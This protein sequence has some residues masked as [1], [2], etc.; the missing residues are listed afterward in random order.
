MAF[1]AILIDTDAVIVLAGSG[2]L[3]EALAQLGLGPEHAQRL[4]ALRSQLQRGRKFRKYAPEVR[5][6]AL[7]QAG[8]LAPATGA[9]DTDL[10]DQLLRISDIDDGE[11]HLLALLCE[12][13]TMLLASGDKRAL[14][15]LTCHAS[16]SAGSV[17]QR[18][19]GRII[20]LE[21]VLRLLV[22]AL[23]ADTVGRAIRGACPD[24]VTFRVVF[25]D[26][27]L[28]RDDLCLDAL[29]QYIRDLDEAT[30][31]TLLWRPE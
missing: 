31:G 26:T 23:G 25:S 12:S 16:G 20:C 11:A 5:D 8:G 24:H 18:A 10:V 17:A 15:A 3:Q 14:A 19:A 9:R 21:Q 1:D 30:G 2:L 27:N 28:T 4:P 22:V 29:D 6:T 7:A 13:E